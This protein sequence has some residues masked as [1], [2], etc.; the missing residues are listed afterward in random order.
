MDQKIRLRIA[1]SSLASESGYDAVTVRSL[2]R[3]ASVST[4]T[5]YNHY[6]SVEDCLASVV[7]VTIQVLVGDVREGQQLSADPLD[8]L[9]TGL[10][11]LMER[12][13]REPQMAQAVFIEA[14]AAGPR[15]RA[16][17]DAGLKSLEALLAEILRFAPRPVAGTAHMAAGLVA[18]IVGTV[19][20]TAR[21]GKAEELPGL[22]D[23][24][25]DWMLSVAH[26]EVVTFFSLRSRP[27]HVEAG[28]QSR[29]LASIHASGASLADAGRRAIMTT[30]R[31]AAANG[32]AGLTSAK[33][34]HDAGLSRGEFDRHF[35]GV[36]QCFLDAI[37]S[38]GAAAAAAAESST[39]RAGSWEQWVYKTVTTLAS[40]AA[41]D[42]DLSRLVLL[43]VTAPGRLGVLRRE[44]M[45]DRVAARVREQA[46]PD[47]RPS[48]ITTAASVR[49]IWRIAE[50]EVAAGR[51]GQLRR[52]APVFVY[53]VL[54][55]LRSRGRSAPSRAT[56]PMV[57]V[58]EVTLPELE[59]QA[60]C[61]DISATSHRRYCPR[62]ELLGSKVAYE[63]YGVDV[64]IRRYRRVDGTEVERQVIEHPGSVAILAHDDEFVYLVAQPRE[65][66][67]L[68]EIPAG[69]LDK[70]GESELE[71][72]RRELAEEAELAA[73]DWT[74]LAKIYP[75]PG[76]VSEMVTIFLATGLSP[77]H[78]ERDED[79]AIE[80]VR[81]PLAEIGA[82]LPRIRDAST[83]IALMALRDRLTGPP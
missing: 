20:K 33:I 53:M 28:G 26:E 37:E 52:V 25:T 72:A 74:E 67:A 38:I 80:I 77:A 55:T 19:R 48:E 61:T 18:G 60:A 73:T 40:L 24:L 10:L 66:D 75:R 44:E 34:R 21:T 14:Y 2:I 83:L 5:F 64:V 36:E 3:R 4:S 56:E 69:T 62:M 63:G 68:L 54:A 71:C 50:T 47:R 29:V 23:E 58:D 6:D 81:L 22:T 17:I 39:G 76:F 78:G 8:G 42:R 45:I 43:D 70:E 31:L 12:L 79:E 57:A 35:A 46:P 1:L 30:A 11:H 15:V 65:E 82:E 27:P 7:G 32:L 49:A 13:A 16:E 41:D 51:T 59:V 9:R